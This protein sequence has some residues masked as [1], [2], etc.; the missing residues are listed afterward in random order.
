M[1]EI[2]LGSAS[3][4]NLLALQS[5]QSLLSR[6]SNR[7]STG[8]KV[9]KPIDDAAAFFAAQ[10]LTTSAN[11]N[12]KAQSA[13]TEAANTIEAAISGIKSIT[14]LVESIQGTLS[15]LSNATSLAQSNALLSQYNTLLTQIDNLANAASYQGVNL[16]NT[17]TT[18]LG[19][20]FSGRP[21][22]N[23]LT[24]TAIRSDSA[25]LSF[26][27]IA[28]GLFFQVVTTIASQESRASLQSIASVASAASR[29]A[30]NASPALLASG[31]VGS[32]ASI[33]SS[34]S[35]ASIPSNATNAASAPSQSSQQ[36]IESVPSQDSRAAIAPVFASPSAPSIQTRASIASV[37]SSVSIQSIAGAVVAGVN[38]SLVT[39]VNTQVGNALASLTAAQAT[40]GST[41]AI[42]AVRLE[43]S[44][45]YVATLQ[46]GAASLT[47]A[48]LNEESANLTSLQ[49][50]QSLG[51]VSLSISNQ[52]RQSL[53]R[54]F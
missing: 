46:S 13:I 21:G 2:T 40:L 34:G 35:Q 4:S 44:K 17:G 28:A 14:K 43:F 11:S 45:S 29:A 20:S 52:A 36:S 19:V 53:L 18:T 47:V 5:T 23:D 49:T 8:L 3:R 7:L 15:S 51:V 39:A 54:L 50:A 32:L 24:I 6:T 25:G 31:A 1:S 41:N 10:A 9:S 48:D 27:T 42:L 26:S 33:A 12:I 22:V 16:I 37:G 38:V 30:V